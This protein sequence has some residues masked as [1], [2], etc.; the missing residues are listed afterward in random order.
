MAFAAE[1]ALHYA[2]LVWVL[3]RDESGL[4]AARTSVSAQLAVVAA[5]LA[6][7]LAVVGPR[8][9]MGILPPPQ[10][11]PRRMAISRSVVTGS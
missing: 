4:P 9:A 1:L 8:R 6:A 3:L 11:T 7:Y 10:T 5:V 2:P